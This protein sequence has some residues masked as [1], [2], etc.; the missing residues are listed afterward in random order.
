MP[1]SLPS[2]VNSQSYTMVI[3]TECKT[4]LS[5]SGLYDYAL[6]PYRGCYHSC[7]YCYA[8]AILR[9]RREWG[10]FVEVKR[11]IPSVIA[12]ETKTKKKGVVGISTVTDAYQPIETEREVTRRC[13][14]VLLKC[15]FPICIQTKSSLVLRD[16]DLIRQFANKEVGF[17]ITS[18]D[19][20][21]RK[22]FEPNSSPID[23]RI[24]ALSQLSDEGIETWVF[25][26]PILPGI[27][28]KGLETLVT[29]MA[30]AG[31][32]TIMV[33]KFRA[34]PGLRGRVEKAYRE[35]Y[36]EH[37][38][39]FLSADDAYYRSVEREISS[40]AEKHGLRCVACF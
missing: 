24:K 15:D 21:A 39:N 2:F 11:N 6:N 9:E 20:A 8:P 26:G 35:A 30:G 12:K 19:E 7:V 37:L 16:I 40:L 33:D 38:E 23:E 10:S 5:P 3:E 17:T 14:E 31:V 32:K 4:A 25:I 18:M 1:K 29:K 36:P 28:E 13:L 34:K 27:T 22:V